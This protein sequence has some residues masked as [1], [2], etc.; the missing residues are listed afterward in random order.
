MSGY[1][2]QYSHASSF[3]DLDFARI[4]K[5]TAT[6]SVVTLRTGPEASLKWVRAR[7]GGEKLNR[8]S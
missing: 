6:I 7:E 8:T 5:T 3:L 1:L 4:G 2:I